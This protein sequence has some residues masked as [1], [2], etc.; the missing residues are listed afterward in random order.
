MALPTLLIHLRLPKEL[1]AKLDAAA[2]QLFI[3][4]SE[5][6][7]QA[8][9]EKLRDQH[10]MPSHEGVNILMTDKQLDELLAILRAERRRR[11]NRGRV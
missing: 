3:D 9:V 2:N 1:A 7:R 8:I 10:T 6:I 11:L 4:R 5:Y